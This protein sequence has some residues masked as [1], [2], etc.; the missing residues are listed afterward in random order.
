MRSNLVRPSESL[1]GGPTPDLDPYF[2]REGRDSGNTPKW[3]APSDEYL[4]RDLLPTEA[5]FRV[6][7]T[8]GMIFGAA[9][10][11]IFAVPV[12]RMLVTAAEPGGVM[13]APDWIW[14]RW[15]ARMSVDLTLAVVGVVM[16]WGL[17]RLRPWARWGLLGLGIVPPAALASGIGT[18]I[19]SSD[20]DHRELGRGLIHPCVGAFVYPASIVML[21]AAFGRRGRSILNSGYAPILARTPKQHPDLAGAIPAGIGL[22][23]A[24]DLGYWTVLFLILSLLV[25]LGVIRTV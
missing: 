7:G 25:V 5:T 6:A 8:V 11:V 22:A 16:S 14:R 9:T 3:V 19:W 20:P 10:F 12:S 15:V 21:R 4:R 23:C 13:L 1:I 17:S 18:L 24:I 2:N